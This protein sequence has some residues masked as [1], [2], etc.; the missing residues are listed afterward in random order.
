MT[1]NQFKADS[2]EQTYS[3][4]NGKKIKINA[5]FFGW[6]SGEDISTGRRFAGYK[7]MVSGNIKDIN[8][9]DLFKA[10]Y[11][12]VINQ[13]NLPWY[14]NYKFATTDAERFKVPLSWRN[15]F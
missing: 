1:K 4:W 9:A 8:K 13:E 2:N 11:A 12:W 15:N 3:G 5:F 14:I 7:Y 6:E 10:F